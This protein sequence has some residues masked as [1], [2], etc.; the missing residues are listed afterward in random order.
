MNQAVVEHLQPHWEAVQEMIRQMKFEINLS[1][2][3]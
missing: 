1:L 2:S 3:Y